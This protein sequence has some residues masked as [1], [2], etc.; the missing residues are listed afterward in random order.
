MW[1]FSFGKTIAIMIKTMPFI[2]FRMAVFFGIA[3]G[4]VLAT[5]AGAGSGY[6]LG[7]VMSADPGGWAVWGAIFGFGAVSAALY[8]LREWILWTV[9]AGHIAVM[10]EAI[11]G[12]E[13]PQGQGQIGFAAGVV[14]ERFLEANV[15]FLVDQLVKGVI[16]VITGLISFIGNFIPIQQVQSLIN[17]I[18][19]VLSYSLRFLAPVVLAHNIRIKSENPWATSQDA[20]VLYAQ[21]YWSFLKN[22]LWLVLFSYALTILIFVVL[23]VPAGFL[24]VMMPD[25]TSGIWT[26]VIAFILAISFKA[27]IL[28]PF[29]ICAMIQVFNKVTAGETPD[30]AWRQRLE[31]ASVKFRQMG[32]KAVSWVRGGPAKPAAPA[33]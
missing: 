31:G 12:R 3:L 6:G 23:M 32:E 9:Q 21:N 33:V 16:A 2:L 19:Q 26:V 30:P 27:A 17:F 4:Y 10:V 7:A 5:G 20:V 25:S 8:W 15:L 18:N 13:L 11:E 1:D 14:R 29:A 28:D 22:A 24:A